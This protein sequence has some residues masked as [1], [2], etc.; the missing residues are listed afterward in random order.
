MVKMNIAQLCPP[1][2]AT[3]PLKY[4]GTE[5]VASMLTE[6]LVRRGHR[7]TLY[8]TGNSKTKAKLKYFYRK[9]IGID[10]FRLQNGILQASLVFDDQDDYEIVHSHTGGYGL[11]VAKYMKTPVVTTMHNDYIRP[12]TIEFEQ[13]RNSGHFVC[14]SKKQ[15]K[16]L[17]GLRSA[18]VVYNATD[19]DKYRF[20]DEKRDYFF[21][22]GNINNNKGPDLAIKTAK[23]L[24]TRL[25]LAAKVDKNQLP[26][27]ETKVKPF[28]DGKRIM[29][30]STINMEKKIKLYQQARCLL[31]PIRWEEPF[32]LVMIEAMSCGT[33][34]VAMNRG[35][36]PEVIKHGETGYVADNYREFVSYVRKID[37]IDPKAC[38]RW[39]EKKFSIGAMT[40]GYEKTY[41]RIIKG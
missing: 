11:I 31:F 35:S 19:T 34:V 38:R 3:P 6:E 30:Y 28:V 15:E 27:F 7:V 29:M 10:Y 13:Y 32:G 5:R 23:E 39:V 40:D 16:R 8:A 24:K 26:F 25:I 20:C 33:P 17:K 18:G 14:I 2:L 1:I 9:N 36:V 12:G 41:K 21:F 4:G 22:I 37:E